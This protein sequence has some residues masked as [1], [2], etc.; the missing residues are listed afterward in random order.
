MARELANLLHAP[1]VVTHSHVLRIQCPIPFCFWFR[2][3][4]TENENV[5]T[6]FSCLGPT[7]DHCC[8]VVAI[9]VVVLGTLRFSPVCT[10]TM[11][12]L[13]YSGLA[14][15]SRGSPHGSLSLSISPMVTSMSWVSYVERAQFFNDFNNV[16]TV[17]ILLPIHPIRRFG[18]PPDFKAAAEE[19]RKAEEEAA[20]AD[21]K[22]VRGVCGGGGG[23]V[24][25]CR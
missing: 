4:S 12:M 10:Y 3:K 16:C 25:Y 6:M 22:E 7:F 14:E 13:F 24:H 19:E 18:C 9:C 8:A 21:D 23:K 17:S 1:R 11:L 2:S 5:A 15:T 20:K